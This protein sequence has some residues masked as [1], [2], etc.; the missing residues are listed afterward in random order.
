MLERSDENGLEI[1]IAENEDA[2]DFDVL[3]EE[4]QNNQ[5]KSMDSKNTL[6]D[7]A[8]VAV[9]SIVKIAADVLDIRQKNTNNFSNYTLNNN[10]DNITVEVQFS[11]CIT[12]G[13]IMVC[14]GCNDTFYKKYK[15]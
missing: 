4:I 5:N 7:S 6:L 11:K 12:P 8:R 10:I 1:N 2:D 14:H 15:S 9:M 13:Y 3:N